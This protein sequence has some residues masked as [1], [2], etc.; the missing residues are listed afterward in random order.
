MAIGLAA[1]LGYHFSK[2]FDQP[3][4]ALTLSEFWRRWHIS[5]STWLRDYLFKPLG[6]SRGSE[7]RTRRNLL[8]TMLLGGIWH[9]AAW[10]FVLWGMLHGLALV[11][12]RALGGRAVP[13]SFAGRVLRWA[14][15]FHIVVAAFVLFRAPD[16]A[17]I[18]ALAQ[19]IVDGAP[20]AAQ[21]M[22][23]TPRLLTIIALGLG[24]HFVPTDLRQRLEDALR[25][26]PA[27]LLGLV[28]GLAMLAIILAAP[29]G[30]APFIYFQF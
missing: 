30:V 21:G 13:A 11:V 5:P 8:L 23:T 25:P 12:E 15:T 17:T 2:N 22:A 19:G 29:D 14:I 1:L 18:A 20:D 7:G 10:T 24:L 16:L 4:R 28:F 26:L 27:P 3:F 9:G 6:G